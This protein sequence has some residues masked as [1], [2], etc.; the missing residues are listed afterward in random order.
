MVQILLKQPPFLTGLSV[1][2]QIAP[3]FAKH[4]SRDLTEDE[5]D[6]LFHAL[7]NRA[8]KEKQQFKIQFGKE[9]FLVI[10]AK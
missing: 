9:R 5:N 7:A 6:K 2:E 3:K 1:E 10:Y 4:L 8:N